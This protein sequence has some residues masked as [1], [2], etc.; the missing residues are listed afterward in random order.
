MSLRRRAGSFNRGEWIQDVI[1]VRRTSRYYPRVARLKQNHLPFEVQ[2]RTTLDDKPTVSLSRTVGG[3]YAP[4]V[5][6]PAFILAYVPI[7][8]PSAMMCPSIALR[9]SSLL[10]PSW[11]GNSISSA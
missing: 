2:F 10:A 8:T 5:F 7:S 11:I 1:S 6:P 9:T 4:L 3:F